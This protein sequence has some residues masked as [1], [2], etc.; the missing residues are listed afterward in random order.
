MDQ[1]RR[2]TLRRQYREAPGKGGSSASK[3]REMGQRVLLAEPNLSGSAE[4]ISV[5]DSD[6]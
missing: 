1:E 5:C 6:Q 2:R 3:N 4:Q